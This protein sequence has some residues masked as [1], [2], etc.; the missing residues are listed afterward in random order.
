[1]NISEIK[2]YLEKAEKYLNT[3]E[4]LLEYGDY[5]S[6][7]SRAYYSMYYIC[8]RLFYYQ[9]ISLQKLILV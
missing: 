5:D 3:A 6:C 1:M 4:Y 2:S 8:Q 9:K 7:V